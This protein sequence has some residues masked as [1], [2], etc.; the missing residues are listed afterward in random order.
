AAPRAH[1]RAPGFVGIGARRSSEK[2]AARAKARKAAGPRRHNSDHERSP[3]AWRPPPAGSVSQR[4]PNGCQ[5][6]APLERGRSIDERLAPE[7]SDMEPETLRNRPRPLPK[8]K[9]RV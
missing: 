9:A 1:S 3:R 2:L 6:P 8:A 5:R 7:S 4:R